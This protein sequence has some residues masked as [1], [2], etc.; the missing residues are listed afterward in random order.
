VDQTVTKTHD[1]MANWQVVLPSEEMD[2]RSVG[3]VNARELAEVVADRLNIIIPPRKM[4]PW[5]QLCSR[6]RHHVTMTDL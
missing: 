3:E 1:S 6:R 4:R 2:V 5:K